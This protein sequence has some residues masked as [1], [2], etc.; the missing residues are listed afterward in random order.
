MADKPTIQMKKRTN[1]IVLIAILIFVGCIIVRLFKL[2]VLDNKFYQ[3]KANEYHFGTISISANRGAIYDSN[4]VILAQ[5]ATVYKVYMDPDLFRSEMEKKAEAVSAQQKQLAKGEL[6]SGTVIKSAEEVQNEIID[7]LADQLEIKSETVKNAMNENTQYKILKTQVEKPVADSIIA[8]MDEND[9]NSIQIEEDTKRYYPQDELAASVIGFTNADGDGQYGLEYQYDEYLSGT[10]GKVISAKDA[11]GNEMPYRYSKTYEAQDGNSLYL[12]IDRTL[13]Y[14]L[15]K[16]LE[17]MVSQFEIEDRACGIIMNAK[18]GAV[19]AMATAPGFD[20]NNPS[21]VADIQIAQSA[22]DMGLLDID[23]NEVIKEDKAASLLASLTEE[24]YND[25]Y[26]DAREQQWKNKAITELCIPGSVF[27]VIT[28]SAALEENLITLNDTFNCSGSVTVVEGTSPI[29]CWKTSGHGSQSFVEAITNS[30]NPAFIEIGRRLG[31]EK[32]FDYFKAYGLTERT[33]IDLPAEATSYYQ[34]VEGMGPVELASCSFG[35]T[36]KVTPLEMITAYAA[37]INGGNLVTPYVV[38]KIVDNDGNVVMTKEK[39]IKRQVISEETSELMCQTL[40]TVAL[41][42]G[43]Y[44]KGY[45][46][47]GKS[48]TS[49][50]LDDYAGDEED[51]MR[52]V[53][54]YCCFAPA[55]DPEVI[56]LIMADEPMSGEYYG[57]Q[58]AVP[59]SRKV[60]EEI[61]PYLGYYPEY[62]EEEVRNMDVTIPFVEDMTINDAKQALDAKGLTYQIVGDGETVCGQ[63][64]LSGSVVSQGGTVILYT[65]KNYT[66]ENVEV[67]DLTGYSLSDASYLITSAG[68]TFVASGASTDSSSSV[69]QS[70]SVEAG[71]IVPKGTVIELTFG[72]N[73]QSG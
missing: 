58:I 65:Q 24:Q 5:S 41:S 39:T 37:V 20:L 14:S 10:D 56:M 22:Q 21:D 12:T 45:H 30:C 29:H 67:P 27:K 73:D 66:Q 46:V 40:E 34:G 57:S 23:K 59:Y 62:S 11:N 63:M 13:Q 4:G 44:I 28:S 50:K 54:S 17:E 69:V 72:V 33:G 3:E 43:A 9:V 7:F 71:N 60:M 8:F 6:P 64:P 31:S 36:N 16:N 32:F 42:N 38:N 61:L 1:R 25:A 35:Q 55:D 68:L 51:P 52:Y 26:V 19:L 53:A 47:G 70:Q 15:E 49:E 18:T 2:S 48:G